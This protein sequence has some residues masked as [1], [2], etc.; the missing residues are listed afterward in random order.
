MDFG[1]NKIH[2]EVIQEAAFGGT[3]FRHIYSGFN[4]KWHRK[5]WKEFDQLKYID[6][7]NYCT[8]CYGVSANKYGVKYGA[9][10]SFW[11]NEGWINKIDPYD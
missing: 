2:V 10:S 5:S 9:S 3:Y 11:E 6:Q 1:A 8:S 4:R 7:K